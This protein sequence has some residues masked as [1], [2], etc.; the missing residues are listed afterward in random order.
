MSEKT[1]NR[2]CVES[3][4][5]QAMQLTS[6]SAR[7]DFLAR[8]CGSD[9]DI[10]RKVEELLEAAVNPDS[11]LDVAIDVAETRDHHRYNEGS[12][13]GRYK[14]LQQIGE[15]GFGVVYLAE[16]QHPVR[17]KVALKIIKPGMDSRAVVARFEAERQALAMMDHANIA[18]V[19]DGG[20]TEN[21]CPF[22]AM[23]LV[24]GVPITVYCDDNRLTTRARL[25][26]FV[27]V[28]KAVQHAHHKGIIHRD[29][30]PS[31]VMVTLHDGKPVV[32]VIDFGVAKALNQ[33]LT[34][35]TLFTAFG[36]MVG[37]PQYMSPEQ[38]EMSGLDVDTRS[39]IYSLGVLL[40]ELL[41]GTTPLESEQLRAAGYAEMQRLIKE[42]EPPKPS[43]RLSTTG[44]K[45][46]HIADHRS[47]SPERLHREIKGDLDWIVMKALDKDRGRR[48][49]TAAS[50]ETDID[51]LLNDEPI[52]ARPPSSAYRIQ[53][54]IVR[55]KA[56]VAA[57][58]TIGL[59]LFV[60]V[61]GLAV[62]FYKANSEVRRH[63]DTALRESIFAALG[64]D[65]RRAKEALDAARSAGAELGDIALIES[66]L[67]LNSGQYEEAIRLADQSKTKAS[68]IQGADWVS[69]LAIRTIAEIS[70]EQLD[71][72][73]IDG[74][75][76]QQLSGTSSPE[77][78][79]QAYAVVEHNPSKAL[80]ILDADQDIARSP[81][82][83]Y[84][85]GQAVVLIAIDEHDEA[86]LRSALPDL[87]LS[88]Y[89]FRN[90]PSTVGWLLTAYGVGIEFALEDGRT[91]EAKSY[92]QQGKQLTKLKAR[93]A[94]F[95]WGLWMFSRA[96]G[97]DDGMVRAA[98]DIPFYLSAH[99]LSRSDGRDALARFDELS[100]RQQSAKLHKLA[101]AH[102][103][104][105]AGRGPNELHDWVSVLLDDP[106]PI[107]RRHA[108]AAL[109]LVCD[110][111]EVRKLAG[112]HQSD[113]MNEFDDVWRG[114]SCCRFFA[115]QIT[116]HQL[117]NQAANHRFSQG[118]AHFTIAMAHVA[119]RDRDKALASFRACVDTHVYGS[120]DYEL[121]QAYVRRMTVDETWVPWAGAENADRSP[122]TKPPGTDSGL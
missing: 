112:V 61:A 88:R 20:T 93:G 34:E 67:A 59:A 4:F 102:L 73:E 84:I 36:Q 3:L 58:A 122:R 11:F 65:D 43:T 119:D 44:D 49:E 64:G 50:F 57:I 120:Y 85:R 27:E 24:K 12:Q 110:R 55:N 118:N 83:V 72:A 35:K 70:S 101:R 21:G 7:Q 17:R 54:L 121:A 95:S 109:C 15:G 66:I 79:L 107:I 98:N 108:L 13:I 37:T 22:F 115:G 111:D 97:D 45:L 60:A 89:L 114:E 69:A 105:G 92:E 56:A 10:R 5:S 103:L 40:Y 33:Q 63:R 42:T 8:E 19:F 52:S 71:L 25:G 96:V 113:V 81:L 38:A 76:L 94:R 6:P 116:E 48:Y 99:C 68:S 75:A 16:Q 86:K 28:C 14:L 91:S 90:S 41:T 51:R 117:K 46:T 100:F 77:R 47:V 31:N 39:D 18:R 32:K 23:E 82:G 78:L 62:G 29:I 53:K 26:L 1:Q 80:E 2:K 104:L 9:G 30:K 106:S 87:E 74:R